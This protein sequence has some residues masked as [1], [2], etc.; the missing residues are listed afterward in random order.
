MK[1]N[2][3]RFILGASATLAG[4]QLTSV[5]IPDKEGKQMYGLIGKLTGV[6]HLVFRLLS[7]AEAAHF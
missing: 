1:T 4:V 3:R 5:R 7:L 6:S 2:R